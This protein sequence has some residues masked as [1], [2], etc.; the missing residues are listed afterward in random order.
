MVE[1]IHGGG[2]S[3]KRSIN[4]IPYSCHQGSI[5]DSNSVIGYPNKTKAPHEQLLDIK[6]D[7]SNICRSSTIPRENAYPSTLPGQILLDSVTLQ[8]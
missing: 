3:R 4:A 7:S 2:I 5:H 6:L 1:I 8:L